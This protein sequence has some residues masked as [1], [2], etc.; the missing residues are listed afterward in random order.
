MVTR[1]ISS[2]TAEKQCS[3]CKLPPPSRGR[4]VQVKVESSVLGDIC[5]ACVLSNNL[6]V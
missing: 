5:L 3:K 2:D 6:P 4:L 1:G